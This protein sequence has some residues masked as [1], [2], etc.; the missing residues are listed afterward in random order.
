MA[1]RTRQDLFYILE[2][3]NATTAF[4][5]HQVSCPFC[6]V[7]PFS[8]LGST[9]SLKVHLSGGVSQAAL[10]F[11][12]LFKV[13]A[14]GSEFD[15]A[16]K[17]IRNCRSRPWPVSRVNETEKT[18]MLDIASHI[19]VKLCLE[20]TLEKRY[21]AATAT[22]PGL[23]TSRLGLGSNKT[24]HGTPDVQVRGVAMCRGIFDEE[25]VCGGDEE[26]SDSASTDGTVTSDS[27]A[28]HIKGKIR[29]KA[30]NLPQAVAT[31]VV[32]AFTER[33]NQPDKSPL[34]PTVL[35][36]KTSFRVCLYDCE[37]D[38]LLIS[39]AKSLCNKGRM[40]RSGVTLLW[41]VLNHR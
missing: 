37:R 27:T 31:C 5:F 12:D 32:S 22:M 16:I 15:A 33:T 35:I 21:S 29:Y 23:T 28:V 10:K 41:V 25:E 40:S 7:G 11:D 9:L 8:A 2:N 18:V 17:F 39:N 3:L 4:V 13:E 6:P 20:V 14:M 30:S 36:D 26:D 38:V 19:L 1:T 34:I 24:W